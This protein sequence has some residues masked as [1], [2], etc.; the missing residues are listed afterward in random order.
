M[1]SIFITESRLEFC[2][3][4]ERVCREAMRLTALQGDQDLRMVCPSL[5]LSRDAKC[6]RTMIIILLEGWGYNNHRLL[7]FL[8]EKLHL[9]PE[10]HQILLS[11]SSEKRPSLIS[12]MADVAAK[13]HPSAAP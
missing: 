5:N 12:A 11:A 1:I 7:N 3:A 2:E 13:V 10:W 6:L 4:G 9:L 8:G